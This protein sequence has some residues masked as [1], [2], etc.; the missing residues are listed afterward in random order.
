MNLSRLSGAILTLLFLAIEANANP[1]LYTLSYNFPIYLTGVNAYG[2]GASA[3][4]N[5]GNT[6]LN[7]E[8]FCDD[9]AH[10]IWVPYGPPTYPGYLGV[11]VSP[12]SAGSL[13]NTRFGG[14]NNWTSVNIAGDATDSNTINSATNALARYQMVAYLIT[15]YHTL[16]N[17]T[18]DP[19]NNGIQEAIWTLMD[20]TA[21]DPTSSVVTLPNIG[22]PTTGLQHAAQWYAN[23]NSDKSF[24]AN[25]RI[26]SDPAMYNCGIGELCTGF[27]EQLY[28]DVP[29]VPEPRGQLLIILGLLSLCA[30]R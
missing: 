24:L 27:Q 16:D 5:N 14:V 19:Y 2:G 30:F 11:N 21:I 25:F 3:T 26:I 4:L 13:G 1:N 28:Q 8:I 9:F 7:V 20:P 6:N 17:P 29:A 23:P 22:D 18:N 10:Q 15:Q 12:L